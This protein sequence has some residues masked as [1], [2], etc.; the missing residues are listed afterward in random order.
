MSQNIPTTEKTKGTNDTCIAY[1]S[2][3]DHSKTLLNTKTR[4][5]CQ[6]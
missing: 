1:M 6:K 5:N 2:C 3:I 4:S